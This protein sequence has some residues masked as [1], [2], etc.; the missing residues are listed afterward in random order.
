MN[1]PTDP[2][3]SEINGMMM[4]LF[5]RQLAVFDCLLELGLTNDQ[6]R[7][8]VDKSR[9]YLN[10]LPTTKNL[11]LQTDATSLHNAAL[12]LLGTLFFK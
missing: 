7:N 9:E 2:V 4:D 12:S 8:H 11:R 10:K 5:A 6:I 1:Q 3:I